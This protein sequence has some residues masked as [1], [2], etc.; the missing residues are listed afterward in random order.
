MEFARPLQ[1][2]KYNI[3]NLAMLFDP[4]RN[5]VFS[6]IS[7]TLLLPAVKVST[8][9]SVF[10]YLTRLYRFTLTDY[11]SVAPLP[12]LK[13]NVT[14]SVPRLSTGSWLDLTRQDSHLLYI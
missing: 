9:A 11:G 5:N 12:T 8:S 4:D 7:I 10:N 1:S 13:P 14:T 6:P 2:T 3:V